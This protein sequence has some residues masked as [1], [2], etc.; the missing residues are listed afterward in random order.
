MPGSPTFKIRVT[1]RD[2]RAGREGGEAGVTPDARG[3]I[4]HEFE[5]D[6]P[7]LREGEILTLP[8][9]TEV[10]MIGMEQQINPV[11]Q[12]WEQTVYVGDDLPAD[13]G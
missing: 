3:A 10:V 4:L 1:V 2:G 7:P 13:L 12:V 9:G 5:K 6:M 8:D 11:A